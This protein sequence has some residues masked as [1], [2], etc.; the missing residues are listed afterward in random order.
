MGSPGLRNIIK[1]MVWEVE[2]SKTL[3]IQ[4]FARSKAQKHYKYNGLEGPRLRNL[5]NTM[6]WE[7][8]RLINIINTMVLGRSKAQKH[9]KYNCLEG[10]KAQKHYKCNGLGGRKDQNPDK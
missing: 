2:G 3:K 4:W 1:T 7:V 5:I 6:V 9:Y 10:R 8:E